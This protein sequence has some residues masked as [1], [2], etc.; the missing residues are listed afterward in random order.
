M[1]CRK[2]KTACSGERPTCETCKQ[3]KLE[4]AGYSEATTTPGHHRTTTTL[5]SSNRRQSDLGAGTSGKQGNSQDVHAK[6]PLSPGNAIANG[7]I[8]DQSPRTGGDKRPRSA[9]DG[10]HGENGQASLFSGPRN[11]MPYF[12]WLGPTAIMPGFKQMVVKVRR[13]DTEGGM[14]AS[15]DGGAGSPALNDPRPNERNSAAAY[16]VTPTAVESD[17]RTPLSLPFYD[18]SSVPPS[19]LITHLANTFFTHLGCNYPFLQH[20]R[21]L[22]DLEEKQVDPVLVDAVCALAARFST[23]SLLTQSQADGEKTTPADYGHAFAQRAKSALTE[24]FPCPSVAASQAALLL[25]YN[26]FGEQR[27]SGLWMYLG[28]SVRLAQDLGLHKLEGLRYVGRDGPTPRM[29]KHDL[30]GSASRSFAPTP[31]IED[32]SEHVDQSIVDKPTM[33]DVQKEIEEARAV[34]QERV[35]TFWAIFFLDR[36]VSSGTGRRATLRDKDIEISLPSL[37]QTHGKSDWPAPF[38]ALIRIVH[39]YGRVADLLN[40]IKEPS[41][42]TAETPKRLAAMESQ[43]TTFYQNLSPRLHFDAVN[44]QHYMKASEGTNFVLLHFWFHAL[45]VILH[46]PTLLKTFAGRMLQLFPNSQQL[47]MSSAKTIAD[48]LS[49]SQLMDGKASLG[50][51]FT[52]QPIYIAAC[53]FLRETAE[54]TATSNAQSRAGSP[55]RLA[56]KS[57]N[58]EGSPTSTG[59]SHEASRQASSMPSINA[60][61]VHDARQTSSANE[62][63]TLAKH[64]LLA[65]AASQHYQLCYKALQSLE[66][67]WAGTKY[68]LTVLDQKFEGVGDPLLYTAEEGESSMEQPRPDP[69][70]TSPGWRRKLSWSSYVANANLPSPFW[71]PKGL[72]GPVPGSPR[73]GVDPSKGKLSQSDDSFRLTCIDIYHSHWVDIFGRHELQIHEPGLA[74]CW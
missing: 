2:R 6:T 17:M 32:N 18:T 4:C 36:V 54:Q 13:S 35:D 34:E 30:H 74:L 39:L 55:N 7:R 15:T 57:I 24:T 19:E 20:D 58:S 53:A 23:H 48:I 37:T 66:A 68:I 62:R 71:P 22:K 28:I 1:T 3:N 42:I 64:T 40:S 51:P 21:F 8:G 56:V 38:P 61:E 69:V 59:P 10:Q 50:N 26:E 70:F 73:D 29:V 14:R 31:T 49:Y 47:S 12:R 27:D 25:A 60:T 9:S 72:V 16:S 5:E 43:V 41:D 65:T 33:S 45:I 52:S 11:R 44:F 67:Y 46:Q 63:S